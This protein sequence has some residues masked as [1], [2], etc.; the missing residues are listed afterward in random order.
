MR[1][2][3]SSI[4]E[5]STFGRRRIGLHRHS[6]HCGNSRSTNKN[7]ACRSAHHNAVLGLRGSANSQGSTVNDLDARLRWSLGR[8]HGLSGSSNDGLDIHAL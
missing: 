8:S 6:R 7:T 3:A 1:L 4:E 2:Q 5:S